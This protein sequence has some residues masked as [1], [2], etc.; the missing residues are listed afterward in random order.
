MSQQEFDEL[1][2]FARNDDLKDLMI[3]T[4]V[5]GCRPQESLIVAAR[6]V[7]LANQ[8]WVFSK[9]E[10]KTK[11]FSRVVYLTDEAAAITRRRMLLY[12][13]GPIFRNTSGENWTTDAVNCGFL[14]IQMR[15]GRQEMERQ[16]VQVT[17]DDIEAFIPT[18]KTE[19][20]FNGELRAKT[21]AELRCEAKRRLT[22][23]LASKYAT[24]HSLYT[25][26]HSWATNALTRGLEGSVDLV[27]NSRC[28]HVLVHELLSLGGLGL[29][30][31]FRPSLEVETTSVY[32]PER[33][34][35]RSWRR[36]RQRGQN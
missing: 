15:M 36:P 17:D 19:P 5:T 9:S 33:N 34:R 32:L 8:R 11:R 10:E 26:R 25:L 22:H 23:K 29:R 31:T 35:E 28:S 2:L 24:R 14:A 21:Q 3:T 16:D 30:G 7:D 4:W 13:S 12:P 6:H 20:K 1:L 18:L 27:A